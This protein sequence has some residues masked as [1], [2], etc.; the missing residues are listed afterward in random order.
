RGAQ[1]RRGARPARGAPEAPERRD[2]G[3]EGM[4]LRRRLSVPPRR[5][6]LRARRDVPPGRARGAPLL[7][8][9]AEWVR[10]EAPPAPRA[11]PK[12]EVTSGPNRACPERDMF[13]DRLRADSTRW[14]WPGDRRTD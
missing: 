10:S 7:R 2:E 11:A 13:G 12:G 14:P 3:D 9:Q 5:R 1:G 8:S 4:G 6:R